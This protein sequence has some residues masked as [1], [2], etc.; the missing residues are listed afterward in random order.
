MIP[1]ILSSLG[2]RYGGRF[3]ER[4]SD[5]FDLAKNIEK[6]ATINTRI[7]TKAPEQIN[8][9]YSPRSLHTVPDWA[10]EMLQTDSER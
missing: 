3:E 6:S 2:K 8:A 4:V 7:E 1:W 9:Y 5:V 10:E